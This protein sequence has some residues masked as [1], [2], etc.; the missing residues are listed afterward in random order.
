MLSKAQEVPVFGLF[1]DESTSLSWKRQ[2]PPNLLQHEAECRQKII[3]IRDVAGM[4]DYIFSKT[5]E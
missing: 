4:V 2:V 5:G 1:R 3:E